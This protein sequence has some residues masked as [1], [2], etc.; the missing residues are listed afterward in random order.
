MPNSFQEH[1]TENYD[2]K[3]LAQRNEQNQAFSSFLSVFLSLLGRFL[4][5]KWIITRILRFC[6]FYE[7]RQD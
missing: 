1:K 6:E 5:K 7:A 3:T 4:G 2:M